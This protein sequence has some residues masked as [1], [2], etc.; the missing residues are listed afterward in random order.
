ME[1]D[2]FIQVSHAKIIWETKMKVV[3]QPP[4][5]KMSLFLALVKLNGQKIRAALLWLW[6]VRIH[7][8]A[9]SNHV[10]FVKNW[11]TLEEFGYKI[12]FR[13]SLTNEGKNRKE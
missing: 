1:C 9:N 4:K 11:I 6:I 12:L 2:K 5:H 10:S 3:S 8:T 13:D 7:N